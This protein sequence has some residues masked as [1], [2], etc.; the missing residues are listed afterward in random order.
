MLDDLVKNLQNFLLRLGRLGNDCAKAHVPVVEVDH[1]SGFQI[2]LV[3]N[4]NVLVILVRETSVLR[5]GETEVMH[6]KAERRLQ[7]STRL[8][9]K[10]LLQ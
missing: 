4:A 6:G 9:A 5:H 3:R 1:P 2:D 7:G 10:C 8:G